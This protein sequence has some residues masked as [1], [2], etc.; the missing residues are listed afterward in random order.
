LLAKEVDFVFDQACKD[1]YNEHKRR[2]TFAS[3]MQPPIWDEPF[4]IMCNASD[5]MVGVAFRNE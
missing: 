3:I 1:A 5:Y 2:V 4:E